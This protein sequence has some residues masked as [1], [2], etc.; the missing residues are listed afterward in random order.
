MGRTGTIELT[1]PARRGR[2]VT[3]LYAAFLAF[4]MVWSGRLWEVDLAR[5]ILALGF[6]L[7]AVAPFGLLV[8]WLV[9][10]DRRTRAPAILLGGLLLLAGAG[11]WLYVQGL[12]L[13]RDALSGILF[14]VL[15]VYQ[16]IG[17]VLTRAAAALF[18]RKVLDV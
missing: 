14:A 13:Q 4:S 8:Y 2:T 15:P 9:R 16:F 10:A 11:A 6:F 7:W 17:A 18:G 3:S 1:G 5:W 12:F